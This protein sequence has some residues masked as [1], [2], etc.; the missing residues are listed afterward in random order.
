MKIL[1]VMFDGGGNVPPQLKVARAL[2][3]RGAEIQV[4][5]H[6]GLR[7]R[8]E[9]EGL[10]F[11]DFANG[12]RFD[13]VARRTLP[14][15][16]TDFAKVTMDRR[17]GQCAVDVARRIGADAVVVDVVFGAAITEVVNAK[18]P[19]VAFVH[20]FYRGVQDMLSSPLG[21]LHRLRGIT[22][23]RA[24][25]GALLQIVTARADL[26]PMRGSPPVH[27]VGVV[28][29]SV[30][31]QAIPASTP[32]ILVSLSTCA[33]AGQRR[34]LQNIL[35]AI[36]PLGV[37]AIVTVG[38]GIDSAG[39]RVPANC[40]LHSWLDHDEVLACASLVVGHGG[41]STAMR[42]LSFGVPLVV[43]PA[44]P[45]I[46]QKRVGAQI[47]SVGAGILLSKHAGS[48]RIRAAIE[49]AL[50]DPAYRDAAAGIGARIRQRDGAEVA[51]DAIEEFLRS[52]VVSPYR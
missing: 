6:S 20:C 49:K 17:Y 25:P 11:E 47:S 50:G 1:F 12:R 39:L 36:E 44:N 14:A 31:T 41:H 16:M 30:P 8:I 45:L 9:S 7:E 18:I 42:A 24:D 40:S 27:H 15:M 35:D 51:A 22:P 5:G 34:M 32:R 3:N 52:G 2:T 4:L 19:A 28:W 26:D 38:P 48:K 13:P 43:M 23:L 10:A 29:Q 33:Y 46:D 37:E 21:W